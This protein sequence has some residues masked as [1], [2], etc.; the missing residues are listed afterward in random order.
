MA[1]T[2]H[3]T[4]QSGR[5]T[6]RGV[7][8]DPS[9]A[10]L[11]RVDVAAV[12]GT[13]GTVAHGQTD[14]GGRYAL[15]NL[16]VGRYTVTFTAD[17]FGTLSRDD[18]EAGVQSALTLDVRL[19]LAEFAQG[20]TVSGQSPALD[21]RSSS[22]GTSLS[23]EVVTSLPLNM[24][25]GRSIENFAYAV[26]PG[27]EGNNWTANIAGGTA[28]SKEVLLD[29]TSATIQIQGHI[30]ESSPP[31]DAVEEFKVETSGMSAEYGRTGGGLF[32]FS[33]C[34]GTNRRHGSA[35]GQ[36]RNEALNANTAMN[37]YL[38]TADPSNADR[39]AK[40]RDRQRLAGLSLGGPIISNRTFYFG[41]FEEYRQTRRQLGPHDRTVPTPAFLDGDFSALL[42]RAAPLGTDAAGTTIYRGAIFDP[43]TA[44]VF[45]G[46]VIP[47][48]RISPVSRRIA[49]LYRSSYQPIDPGRVI[50]NAAGPAYI[51]PAAT[52]QQASVKLD[53]QLSA[54]GRL[55][56]SYLW[57]RRPRTLVDQGGVW[58]GSDDFGGPLAKARKHEVTTYQARASHTQ[59][60]PGSVLHVATVTFSRFRNPST[61][62]S[63]EGNWPSQLGLHVPGAYDSFPQID[64]GNATNG[65]DTTGIGYGISNYYVA[66]VLQLNDSVTWSRGRHLIK[67]GGELRLIEMSS[68]GDRAYLSY[69]F[70][71]TQTGLQGGPLAN[72]V[73]FG[74]ASFLLGEV[75]TA[76]QH[77]PADFSGHRN[78]G[79]LFIQDE[80][81]LGDAVTLSVGL[82]WETTGGWRERDGRWANFNTA[83]VNPITGVPGTLEYADEVDG[84][85]EGG[86]R[87]NQFGPRLGMA[88]QF[89][90]RLVARGAYGIFYTPI[91]TNFWS[92]VPYGFAP[93]YYGINNIAQTPDGAA[94]FNWDQTAYPGTVSLP[95]R[96]PAYTQWG[97]V[98]THP[99]SLKA[100]RVQQWSLGLEHELIRDL[101]V[102]VNYVGNR[103]SGLPSGDLERN[104]P[105]PAA[106]RQ[107]LSR[108]TEWNWVADPASAAD[109]GVPYPYPGFAGS[110]WMAIT[111]YPQAAAGWGP[112]FFVGSPLGQTQYHAW[113]FTAN[114]RSSRGIS[115][116]TSYTWSR[117][118]GNVDSLFQERWTAGAIQDITQ[119]AREAGVIGTND[120]THV[121]KGYVS[122][123]LPRGWNISAIFRYESGLPLAVS[124][125][126]T[127]AGWHYPIYANRNAG[128]SLD[129]Q[130]DSSGFNATDPG[131][132]ANRYFDPRAFSNP[133]YGELGT[134]PGRIEALRGF[135]AAYEDL[136]IVKA[137][138]LGR[139]RAQ[140]KFEVIN[141][142][143]RRYFADPVTQL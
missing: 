68:Y 62:A 90:D 34:S 27:V 124:S 131:D 55:S 138:A 112:L 32:N 91:G 4:A 100:G 92:G 76:S 120:R 52:L 128:V 56:G 20:L 143:N 98:S 28:F 21:A 127:Y 10:T 94:A 117:Q 122:W 36:L 142:F 37:T 83:K 72:H 70:S 12:D 82:R 133:A 46:N 66:D 6:I 104:Q 5:A 59:V 11:A 84:S 38:A 109:A 96:D 139:V 123:A 51:D 110:A 49:E 78:Y 106:M 58:D 102:G 93:G 43:R 26:A 60:L 65:I 7:V 69:G 33:L 125:S 54:N 119:L 108:G 14:A 89:S 71:P 30:T 2:T 140:L 141:L 116:A 13:T 42:D 134:G 113:Q 25:G 86:R 103:G 41:A 115:A 95:T 57:T 126:N 87:Y 8:T 77:V 129:R 50:N 130:F 29:G 107:L 73:G 135:G 40:P 61:A 9:G 85:F 1:L 136:G 45:P 118:R 3:A 22:L 47:A 23:N 16:P 35:H 18:L 63:A 24:T 111:P 80:M 64:F 121:A 97:L 75:A 53:H 48:G 132:P 15:V 137:F 81:R 101:T 31:L 74:F 88:Y 44:L 39:Y 99:D 79:A 105:N 114:K 67:A 19:S 17:G